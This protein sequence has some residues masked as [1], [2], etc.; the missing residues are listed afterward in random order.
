MRTVRADDPRTKAVQIA[1]DL[2]ERIE[3]GEFPAGA[4]LPPLRKLSADYGVA[5]ETAKD[6]LEQ[7]CSDG[8]AHRVEGRGYFVTGA[9]SG[10]AP[11]RDDRLEAIEAEVRELRARVANLEAGQ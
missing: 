10:P 9:Q 5:Q 7:L 1:A 2:R 6:G 8:S 11:T 4:K 3:A